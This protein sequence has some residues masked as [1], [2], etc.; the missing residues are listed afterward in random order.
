[1][2]K[3]RGGMKANGLLFRRVPL[4]F[5]RLTIWSGRLATALMAV[6][7]AWLAAAAFW[8]WAAPEHAAPPVLA[9]ADPA[10]VAAQVTDRHLF[11]E[12][13]A[14]AIA[15][16]A[17]VSLPYRLIGTIAATREG[18]GSAILASDGGPALV[19]AEGKEIAPGLVLKRV[20]SQEVEVLRNGIPETL[21]LPEKKSSR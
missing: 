3:N 19:V 15:T 12:V 4:D 14:G 7:A 11:G 16:P 1:M 9:E 17:A 20:S 21:R 13:T 5:A 18:G 10:R 6:L 8:R 2:I